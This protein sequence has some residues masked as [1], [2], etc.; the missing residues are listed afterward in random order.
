M[1]TIFVTFGDGSPDFRDAAIRLGRQAGLFEIFHEVVVLDRSRL[2]DISTFAEKR[3]NTYTNL[4]QDSRYLW[5]TKSIILSEFVAGRLGSECDL[6]VYA[7]AGCEMRANCLSKAHLSALLASAHRL[8]GYVESTGLLEKHWTKL[9]TLKVFPTALWSTEQLQ[10]TWF[11]VRRSERI[12]QLALL[13]EE[14][15]HPAKGLWQ[16]PLPDERVQPELVEH[17]H[18]QSLFSLIWKSLDLPF[19]RKKVSWLETNFRGS[20]RSYHRPILAIRNR[21]GAS[22]MRAHAILDR[23][24][25]C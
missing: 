16:D 1:K 24:F 15:S 21:T 11:I 10:S 3:L 14:M 23:L 4:T 9:K 18:D 2:Q 13:W 25:S 12:A 5:S 22:K 17:R 6:L 19:T 7:D 20:L 8:D